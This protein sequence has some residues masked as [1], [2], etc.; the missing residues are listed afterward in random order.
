MEQ[1]Y[2]K[3]G[4]EAAEKELQEKKIKQIKEIVTKY[5]ETIDLKHKKRDELKAKHKDEIEKIEKEIKLLKQDLDDIRDG[6]LDKIEERQ[7]VDEDAKGISLIIIKKIEREYIPMA[8][9]KSPW[10]IIWNTQPISVNWGNGSMMT[11]GGDI[12]WLEGTGSSMHLTMSGTVA[13]NFSTG[14]YLVGDKIINL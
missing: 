9:W 1:K 10:E 2:I 6:R 7:Q 3:Q 14:T 11:S 4:I 13:S 5:L 12:G 8:P